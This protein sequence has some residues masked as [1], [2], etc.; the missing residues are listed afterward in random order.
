MEE[1]EQDDE[2]NIEYMATLDAHGEHTFLEK[3]ANFN[4][5][6]ANNYKIM[7]ERAIQREVKKEV[8]KER[9]ISLKLGEERGIK[10]GEKK[11]M[12]T[13]FLKLIK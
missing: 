1:Y 6:T 5:T 7:F 13:A 11:G 3:L 10:F 2:E 4:P 9:R 12:Q 8:Q